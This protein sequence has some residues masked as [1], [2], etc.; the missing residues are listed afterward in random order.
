MHPAPWRRTKYSGGLSGRAARNTGPELRL[1]SALHRRGLRFRLHRLIAEGLTA[2]IILVRF[3]IA[4]FV[5]GCYWHQCPRHKPAPKGGPNAELWAEKFRRTKMRDS[6]GCQ[7]A[8]RAGY[9]PL[10]IWECEI[11]EDNVSVVRR[12]LSAI[13][14]GTDTLHMQGG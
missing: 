14:H 8:K 7:L 6:R 1:R 4:I 3:R 10:R 13:S 12:I 9:H 5:D 2:D 11:I